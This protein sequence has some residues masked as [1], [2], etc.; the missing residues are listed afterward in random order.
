LAFISENPLNP[1]H[2]RA[3]FLLIHSR[4][5]SHN[6]SGRAVLLAFSAE[7]ALFRR[8][9]PDHLARPIQVQ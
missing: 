6:H 8:N 3:I 1:R 7:D 2:P 5:L 9:N 4:I